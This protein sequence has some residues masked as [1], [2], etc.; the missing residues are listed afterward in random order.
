MA[1]KRTG[2]LSWTEALFPGG[3]KGLA[4]WTG[5]AGW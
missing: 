3:L 4:G 1:V 2:Q 5:W